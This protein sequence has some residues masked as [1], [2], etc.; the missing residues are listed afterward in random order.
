[1]IIYK[2]INLKLIINVIS[3]IFLY[4]RIKIIVFNER[5]EWL[6][7][8]LSNSSLISC[9]YTKIGRFPICI[10]PEGFSVF[11]IGGLGLSL[12]FSLERD[13]SL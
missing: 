4:E 10:F 2:N 11:W 3:R 6:I 1:M 12:E 13:L 7:N 8:Y 5:E 9:S